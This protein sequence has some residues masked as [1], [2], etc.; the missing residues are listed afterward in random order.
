MASDTENREN[1]DGNQTDG[2]TTESRTTLNSESVLHSGLLDNRDQHL[3]K[4]HDYHLDQDMGESMEQVNANLHL[5]SKE[6]EETFGDEED[7][8]GGL[9]GAADANLAREFADGDERTSEDGELQANAANGVGALPVEETSA[10]DKPASGGSSTSA[11]GLLNGTEQP[12]LSASRTETGSADSGTNGAAVSPVQDESET[13]TPVETG[14]IASDLSAVSDVDAALNAVDED[15]TVGAA[16]GI[17]ASA[18]VADG[19]TVTY[20]L[21]DDSNGLFSIDSETGIVTVA[22]ALDAEAAGTHDIVVL[23]T[24]SDGQTQ[25]ETFSIAIR[26]VN[27]HDVSPI[28]TVTSANQLSEGASGGQEIGIEVSASDLDVSDTVSYSIDDPR[29]VIDQDGIVS[30]AENAEFDAET[31]GSVTFTVTATSTDGSTSDQSFTLNIAD[32]NEYAVSDVSDSDAAINEI[33]EDATAG[34]QVGVTAFATDAD[35]TDSVSYTVDDARFSVDENGV[36]TVADGASFDAETEGSIDVTVTATSTDGSTSTETF[37]IAVSDVDE[38]DVSAV[39]DTDATDNTIAEDA[40]AGT[41]VG[42]KASATDADVT[43][44]VSY[45][46]DDARFAVDENGVV[47]V[48]DGASFDAET[49]GS[50]DVTVTATS[51]DGS[52]STD[53]F[54]IA[55]S[56]VDESDVSAVTDTD[57]S[58]NTIAEDATA[59]TTVGVTASATDADVTD[60]VS[61]TVDDT[62]F[63]VDENGVVTVADGASFDAET[64]GS[65]D[66]T[67]TATSTDGSTSTETFT[68]AV[69]DVDESDVSAVTDTDA[70][71]NT[72]AEDATSGTTVGVTASA[73]DADVT[74]SVSYTVD[75]ARFSVDENGVVTVADGASFDAETEGSIDVTVTATSTDGSTSTDT[76]TIAVSD[77]DESDVSAVTDT[78]ASDN[79]IAEDATAG[80]TVGVTASATDAD[81]TDSVSYTV[82]DTRFAVDENGVVTVADGAS[83]DAETEGSIDVTVTATST[84][85]STSTETFTIAVSDVDESDVSAVTDTDATDNTI[86]EDATAGTTVGVTASATD[87]DVTDSVSYTVDDA[88]FAVDENG[89]VTVA[90]GASFDAETEGSIDVT[91]TATSTDG[92][93]STETFTISVSDVD[94]SDVSAVTDTDA[95]DNTIAEDATSGTQV[96]VTASATDADVTDSVSYTVDDARFAVD[97]NGVVTVADGASFDAETEGSIDVTVTATSTDGSTSTETFSIAV[98]DVDESDVSAVTDTDASDN[99]IAEDATAGTTVGVTASA[100]DADVTDSVS[101]TVDDSRFSVDENG[102]VTVADGASFDAETEGSIDVTVTATSTDGSTSTETFTIAVSDVD[103]SDVSAVTDTDATDNT[104][105]EDA[106]AGTQVGVTAS[107]T[108]ADVTDSVSYTVDDARFSVDENGVVTVADG[109]SFDA[110]TEGSIDVTVTATSTDGSTSTETFTIAVS[111]VDESDVSAVTDTDATDNTIAEDATAG[112]QVGVTAFATD[113]DVTDSVSYTVDDARFSV[114]ENGVVTVADGASFDAETE[115]SIDVTVTATSTDGSTSTETF[116]IAVSDVDESDVSAVTDTDASDNTIAEDATAGTQVGVTAFATDADVTDSVS[117]TVD[118]ARFAVDENG[119][120]TVADGASFDAETEGSIDVTVTA[121]STDGSTSTE[122][123]TIAVSDVDESDVS[124]VTDT[125]VTDNTIAEDTTAGTQVGVTALASDADVTDSVSYTV[126]DARFAVDENGVV[127]VA[128]G[129]SFDAETEGS[130]DVTVTATSTDGSTSTETFTIAVSDVDESDVSAV[131]DTDAS[132]NTIAEDATAGTQVGVTAF[133]T[134][135]D[136]TDSVSYTVDDARFVVDENG[137]VTVAD[138]ASFDAET[139]GSIDVTVTATSTDGSSSTETFTIA[140]SDVDESDVSAVTD[141]DATDN[142]IAEDATAGTTVGV[143]ASATDA[144]ITDSV[145]YTVDDA[146]FSVDENGVVTVADGASFDAETEG[147]IDVTVTAT[148]TDG[149]TSTETF[150][151]AVSDVDESD[152]SAVTDTDATDNTIAEDATA[153]TQVGVTALASDADV[154]DS[155]SYTVDDARFAVDENGVVTVADGASFDAETEGSIDVTVTATSTDGST[156]TETFTI[157]VSD[158]DESDVSAVT[159]TDA[160]DSTIAEDATAGTQVGVTAFATDADVTDSVSYTVDDARFV[161]DENGVVTVADGASFDA[162]T[163]GSIDVTVTATSTDGST[164]TDTFTIAVSDVD[165]SDVSAVTDTDASDNTIAEDAT[166]GTTVGV[167]ASATDADVTDSVS[168]TVDDTRFAV[169]ENG[170]V[171]VADGASFDAETEGSIDVTV[172]ATST[173]GSTSTE[174]FT[175]A[176]SDV[177]ES[178]VSAVTDTDATDNTIAEDATAGTT[179]GV[180][181][182]A[183]DADVTD[184]VSYTVDDARFAVDENGVVTVADGASFDAETE[185]SIDVTVTA[186]STDGSTSTETFTISVSDV[187]ESDVSAVTDTDATDNTI[188]EDATSGTQVGVTASATDADVTDSVSYTVDDARFAVDENGVVTVADGASFDAETEGSIDVT[189][190]ATSTDGSTSTETF[191][192]A[193]SDVDESD[194]SAVTDTDASDNTIAEDATA[195]TTVGVT[196]SATDADVTDSVSYTVDDSRFSVDENGVVTVAD[197]A[198]FD[199]ETEG[200]IDVTVTA[201]STDG[202]TSTETFTIAVSDVDESDVSAV[203]DTDATDNTIAE[204]ATAGTQ[205]GVTASATDADVTDSVSYTVD[206]ARFSVDEN[207]VVTVADGA[208]F[209]AETEGSIDVT[210]TATSTDGSTSTET[211]TITVSDVDESDVS[212]VTDTDATVNTIAE[213]ATAGTTVGVTASATDADITDSVSYTV[214]DARFAVDENGVVTVADGASFDAETEGSIDVTVTATSTDGSASTET[215]TI[216]VSDVDE[217]DVSAVTDTDAS[218]NTIAEDAS[219]G[220][221]VGITVSASDGDVTDSVTYTVSDSRFTIDENGEVTIADGASF[222]Y[223]SEPTIYLTV[224]ANSTDG[225]SSQET[226]EVSVADVAEAYQLAD[227]Q[228]DFTDSGVAETSITGN[229]SDN[230]ITAHDDG[231]V[232]AGGDGADT[233]VGGT[234]DDTLDGGAGTDN[235]TL[236][237]GEGSDTY[238]LY[239]DGRADIISDTGTSGTDRIVLSDGTGTEFEL[240]DT[241]NLATQGIEEID[242]SAVSGETLRAQRADATVD[243]DFTGVTLTGVD[244]IEG[245]DG[246]DSI[247]G[248]AGDDTILGGAGADTLTGSAGDDVIYGGAGTDT[249]VFSGDLADYDITLNGDGSYTIV[250]TRAG[251]PDGTDTVFE[252]ENFRFADGDVL[253]GDLIAE[254]IGAVS[255]A[256]SSANSVAENAGSGSTVGVTAFAEDGNTSDTV[257]YTVDDS[258]FAVD[259]NGVVTVADGASFDYE[260][261][262]DVS[263][264][265]TATSSDGSTS[266]ETFTIDVADVAEDLQLSDGGTSFTDTGVSETS[267]TGGDGDDT[268][269][270]H[271][272][273]GNLIGGEGDDTLIGGTGNDTLTGG[274]G[275]DTLQGGDGDDVL[276]A[277]SGATA[278]IGGTSAV[279]ATYSLIHLGNMADI[280]TDET[281]GASENAADLLG[282]YG[283]ANTPLYGQTVSATANDTS[284]DGV[285]AD[286]DF[287][288]TA[289]TFTIGGTDYALDS[290]QVYDATV[291]FTD[292]TTG[293]FS[294]VVI[295]LEGG[296]VY[297]APEYMSNTDSE[298]L[299]SKPIQGISLDTL[300]IDNAGMYA[301]RLDTDYQV[302]GDTLEGGA[303]NDTLIGGEAADTLEGG[304][305]NDSLDGGAGNDTAIYSGN[306]ED[307]D[308][309]DNGDGTYTVTDTRSGAPDGIDTVTNVENFRFADGDVAV[310]NLI[311][312]PVGAVTDGDASANTILENAAAGTQVGITATASDANG[313]AV[314]YSLNDDRFSIDADGVVTIADH[315]FFDSQVE[316]AID[317][318]VTATSSDGS[319]SSETFSVSVSSDYDSEFTGGSGSGSFSASDQSYSVDGV[320]GDD[321]I[322]TG[323]YDD[324]IE[325]GSIDGNDNISGGGGRDLL[326]GQAGSDVISGGSGDDVIVGGTGND[327]LSGGDGSDLF[328]H[329][330]GDGSDVISGG[331]GVAWTDVIDL[332]GGPGVTSAGEY[333]TDW[334]VTITNGSIET[335]D[336]DGKVL[337][338]SQDADGY[339]DFADGSRV[340]FSDVEEIRW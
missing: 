27:E 144:D 226:F 118:D 8:G 12:D 92:S 314:S 116:T 20:S 262:T 130:I 244:Q 110:E 283:D 235:D 187:D 133:A 305:G 339:I 134:D 319:E 315:A 323:D 288:G 59:G 148:S 131:T 138:G 252:V 278:A 47:T 98:S 81:V 71:D 188:A 33:A 129:A 166:A 24:A 76:F 197:G 14:D 86:A 203:T 26:D 329:G 161:V 195:G 108:D 119:V 145:S 36:V 109:A 294:A 247:V 147:S 155:V 208:S 258:R 55:V 332:G 189:V 214:D 242:G 157:A 293:T 272:D 162:E 9:N 28:S 333:G 141:T 124:A 15:A 10:S 97:E 77:V 313:D 121:T 271:D 331:A 101:Y 255:D 206:D 1:K 82:D 64:E 164:S 79:T 122:T 37:T 17:R 90:D 44:S 237:G 96:G 249:A 225:S 304:S 62:R 239:G 238:L 222:D 74:D 152:V 312:T 202:S 324:R 50:I 179:V 217:S 31:E 201:T 289:E 4:A 330:L 181:A 168:Y 185:G 7:T 199:A 311:E 276:N 89:V 112:T 266:Q 49:E 22:G 301:N 257:S 281:N 219:A 170:V 194:V 146:R 106:T 279:A 70:S 193:V 117:Y 295:Q 128:D 54:T 273:G 57:A 191:S 321:V 245:R 107:A 137:V 335:T 232:L 58:D 211:F 83:F 132:D 284:G 209:D 269:T 212:A 286:N 127:T 210:V 32:E 2:N 102:V 183:T 297:L 259:G 34:T 228:S 19:A 196:A 200:S 73:T 35:V 6:E 21:L 322:A 125:D 328:M 91:V 306:W 52:T 67:V 182:S 113:A 298:L 254:D 45:T 66:V 29:F 53:T 136:V 292:G 169:D 234:G 218:D 40:A 93:T 171:T 163:E 250:D 174:T 280:D 223:E 180:T 105:A 84:D 25:T 270:A 61:Y 263:I 265:V 231:G 207:G 139:E 325:G 41:T 240:E 299:S 291:T 248:S 308:I 114:D 317:L 340:T 5:G 123:F 236:Q 277:G 78:D 153:G 229:D 43:D 246:D 241:F 205:V 186:T 184:S 316:S 253:A 18:D 337:E 336:T 100:T 285:L 51:T 80:T 176:V 142:T 268:I 216:A 282:S 13:D 251:S 60:S 143:T 267:I 159:D 135:A 46:V 296:D 192:I 233:L 310:D 38:S 173:D 303:G 274:S 261:E 140:V 224:T 103:E 338:L 65:I 99:T 177:D 326:F 111:D 149:S 104:I 227:D 172:T 3:D 167:T 260:T 220:A 275:S 95:T 88:R 156:S 87:A 158:V 72:I 11:E 334:T 221:Q 30:I 126:D 175:I 16:T 243:W 69:S 120:V 68:I 42:V 309:V 160:S 302:E 48:A 190:T 85:G 115:G 307:Y 287:E 213:D 39:T 165:E 154:T 320:G 300:T 178:D 23:A 256:D 264:T 327:N 75:D 215:F 150:T 63:A 290:L 204:D 318:T 230:T 56:D 151:I 94:E 198:S